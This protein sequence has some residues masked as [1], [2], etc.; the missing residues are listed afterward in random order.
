MVE[1]GKGAVLANQNEMENIA[2]CDDHPQGE[3]AWDSCYSDCWN[4]FAVVEE[5]MS[6]MENDFDRTGKNEKNLQ[7]NVNARAS[8]V[9]AVP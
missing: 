8:A 7:E 1:E 3:R 2:V 4:P 6:A 9:A 5:T